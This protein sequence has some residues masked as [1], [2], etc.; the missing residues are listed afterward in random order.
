MKDSQSMSRNKIKQSEADGCDEAETE[1]NPL[2]NFPPK[3]LGE[4][5][6]GAKVP[7]GG[8]TAPFPGGTGELH[9][10]RKLPPKML[11]LLPVKTA[12]KEGKQNRK[13]TKQIFFPL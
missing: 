5:S 7:A 3:R 2:S 8:D 9:I 13:F 4:D 12:V 11:L 6:G 10:L 1:H